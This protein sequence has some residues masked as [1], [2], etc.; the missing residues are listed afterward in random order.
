VPF[1]QDQAAGAAA[2]NE[3]RRRQ[4]ETVARIVK[5]RTRPNSA[6][7][8]LGD[9]NDP[10]GSDA[11]A[12][13][14]ADARPQLV[15]GL[16]QPK[17]TRPA[18]ADDPMPVSTAWTHRFKP[19][20]KPAHYELFDQVWLSPS[21]AERQV[22]SWVDRRTRLGGDGSDHDPAWVVLDL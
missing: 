1:H 12:P 16:S 19:A 3:R 10:P 17:E 15:N 22:G 7:V 9:M 5:N 8:V 14:V 18:P 2:A 20:R 13:L 6:Y 4:A 11:L 21:L